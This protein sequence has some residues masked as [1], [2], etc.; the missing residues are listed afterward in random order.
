MTWLIVFQE[1]G[2][3]GKGHSADVDDDNDGG[4][5][6]IICTPEHLK[7]LAENLSKLENWKKL[8]PKLGL[9][10]G[11][12]QALFEEKKA[13]EPT[14]INKNF[15]LFTVHCRNLILHKRRFFFF[16][17]IRKGSRVSLIPQKHF[18]D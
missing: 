11:S 10:E 8:A 1:N 15:D 13:K 18:N 14:G 6:T 2:A 16:V 7:Q 4:P 5:A 9:S 17:T 12:M 3:D